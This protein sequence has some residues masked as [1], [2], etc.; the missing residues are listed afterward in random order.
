[1]L[2]ELLYTLITL[3][4]YMWYTKKEANMKKNFRKVLAMATVMTT[5]IS[6]AACSQK[7]VPETV[8]KESEEKQEGLTETGA[9]T[10]T[11]EKITL[12]LAHSQSPEHLIHKT[13][14]NFSKLVSE[15]SG[16]EYNK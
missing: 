12:R 14:E 16:E 5:V 9:E 2:M 15:K 10:V 6:L 7:T 1:M 13:A 11:G 8:G 4:K 3:Q